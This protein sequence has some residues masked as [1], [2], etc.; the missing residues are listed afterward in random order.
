MPGHTFHMTVLAIH[1]PYIA[2]TVVDFH[3]LGSIDPTDCNPPK[4]RRIL[5]ISGSRGEL[6]SFQG[7]KGK[8][9]DSFQL[10]CLQLLS[11]SEIRTI[12]ETAPQ[13]N[14][15][16]VQKVCEHTRFKYQGIFGRT[17]SQSAVR[18]LARIR[19]TSKFLPILNHIQKT[20]IP[21]KSLAQFD[22]Q[23]EHN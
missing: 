18:M 17:V 20:D 14:Q 3:I 4:E 8:I 9:F 21:P 2:H 6:C 12:S 10:H 23:L 7:A 11:H 16:L 5:N 19:I 13:P 15:I 1:Q 22:E